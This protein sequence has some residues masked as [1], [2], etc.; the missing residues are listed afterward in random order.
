MKIHFK[1][2]LTLAILSVVF[3]F[4]NSLMSQ[5][6]FEEYQKR[7]NEEMEKYA[8]Q[9][10]KEFAEFLRKEWEEFQV[11]QGI[12][13]DKTPKP[14]SPPKIDSVKVKNYSG[15]KIIR[16]IQK[17]QPESREVIAE[18]RDYSK[19]VESEN[20]TVLNLEF[21][22]DSI[23]LEFDENWK[24]F[25]IDSVTKKGIAN[26]WKQI[27]ESQF[28][29]FISQAQH[30][31]NLMELNDWAYYLLAN[32]LAENIY[33]NSQK[34]KNLF[35]WFVLIKSGYNLKV[36]YNSNTIYLLAPAKQTMYGLPYLN[37]D[38]KR[39]FNLSFRD[40]TKTDQNIYTYKGNYADSNKSLDLNIYQN[41]NLKK[42]IRTKRLEFCGINSQ[43]RPF[44]VLIKY[45][46]N[47]IEF[48]HNYPQTDFNVYFEA[49]ISGETF[50]SFA[51]GLKP[52]LKGKSEPEAVN[53][54]L[55]LVQKSF[56]YETDQEQFGREKYFFPEETIFYPFSDCEDRAV[57]FAY[58]VRKLL[59]LQVI[60]LNYPGHIATA[61]CFTDDI[62]GDSVKYDN[63]KY[64]ICDPTY[65]NAT[66][67]M[68]MPT[69]KNKKV[70]IININ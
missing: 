55:R 6:S 11:F 43:D 21:F 65:I 29:P 69:A 60:G 48:Y 30:Y 27:S 34:M 39:Y 49:P 35:V 20:R 56:A 68:E 18:I 4:T 22:G 31:K 17:P 3:I 50:S 16:D 33:P 67:G 42:D 2:I 51:D 59:G 46:E 24:N 38:N 52:L 40:N 1:L 64:L 57:L 14:V 12:Q 66:V 10:D 28:Q 53:I 62:E 13:P 26:F 8:S 5:D 25:H 58:L 15:K 9:Q 41:P 61:V 23:S 54:L 36:G 70:E 37:I 47:L 7:Q 45:N 44:P 32:T 19:K 63:K